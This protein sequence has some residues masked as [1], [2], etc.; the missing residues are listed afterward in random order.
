MRMFEFVV[1]QTHV[2]TGYYVCCP[3]VRWDD[4]DPSLVHLAHHTGS[5]Q[6]Q[7]ARAGRILGDIS[8]CGVGR[9]PDLMHITGKSQARHLGGQLLPMPAG[10]IRD[11]SDLDTPLT[12]G[13]EGLNRSR[14]WLVPTIQHTIHVHCHMFEHLHTLPC[15]ARFATSICGCASTPAEMALPHA[16]R[17]TL[18]P[19]AASCFVIVPVAQYSRRPPSRRG[20]RGRASLTVSGRLWSEAPLR[21]AMAALASS[22]F[23][24]STNPKPRERPVYRSVIRCT[25]STVP[26]CSKSSRRS[27]SLAVNAILPTKIFMP[28]SL[29]E[30]ALLYTSTPRQCTVTTAATTCSV[31]APTTT[32]GE[33]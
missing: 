25:L 5:A 32:L 24:I 17:Q 22:A 31:P 23:G 33:C 30:L 1:G 28:H 21:A 20:S 12:E 10:I 27:S 19:R 7:L 16:Y 11:K 2:Q 13:I 15:V 26:C 3:L 6:R 29:S 18:S 14:K 9:S 8:G 4:S